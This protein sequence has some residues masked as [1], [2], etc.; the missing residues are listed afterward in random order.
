[1]RL[2]GDKIL[3]T[4]KQQQTKSGIYMPETTSG[5]RIFTVAAVGP[6]QWNPIRCERKPMSVKVGDRVS[7]NVEIAPEIEITKAGVKM[8]YYI[9]PESDINYILDEGEDA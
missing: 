9:I 1:M 2:T 8:K 4:G 5:K 6:G 7:A 3:L